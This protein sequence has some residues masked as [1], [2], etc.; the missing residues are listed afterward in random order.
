MSGSSAD[1]IAWLAHV[2]AMVEKA[3][4]GQ[5]ELFYRLTLPGWEKELRSLRGGDG[6]THEPTDDF[7]PIATQE[8]TS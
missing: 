4:Q 6:L 8:Q 1:P 3:R 2:Q 5:D 7:Q